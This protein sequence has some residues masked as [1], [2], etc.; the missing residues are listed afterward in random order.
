MI[1]PMKT[2]FSARPAF[3]HV[4]PIIPLALAARDA[5]HDV[6]IATAEPFLTRLA[7]LGLRTYDV[8]LTLP[9]AFAAVDVPSPQGDG[10]PIAE[11]GRP[12]LDVGGRLFIDHPARIPVRPAP[13]AEPGATMPPWIG[14][15]GRPL[16]YLTLGTVVA[17]DDGLL[18][19][20]RDIAA[21]D[22]DIVVA[23]GAA[24]G[25]TLARS[26]RTSTSRR[27]STSRRCSATLTSPCTTAGAARSWAPSSPA[28]RS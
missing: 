9:E 3:G 17:T 7:A 1:V 6:S 21:L 23:L 12:D 4:Y 15:T 18:P 28:H 11:D 26:R 20:I 8:G 14:R 10:M 13:A 16:V 2:L 27:S 5:G 25:S 22:A 24:D 19:A